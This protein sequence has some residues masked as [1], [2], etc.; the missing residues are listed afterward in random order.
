MPW[1]LSRAQNLS[2]AIAFAS[3]DQGDEDFNGWPL[4]VDFLRDGGAPCRL[5][6]ITATDRKPRNDIAG[7]R[8]FRST[9]EPCLSQR[10]SLLRCPE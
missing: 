4:C 1:I 2:H 10:G 3:G 7:R 8:R 5:R 6:R 9:F